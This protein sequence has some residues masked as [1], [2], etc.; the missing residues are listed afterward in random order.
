MTWSYLADDESD[1]KVGPGSPPLHTCFRK[2]QSGNPSGRSRKRLA[3]F[4]IKLHRAHPLPNP[5]P[6]KGPIK[7][8]G[9]YQH[10]YWVLPLPRWGRVGVGVMRAE[11]VDPVE[12]RSGGTP[13]RCVGTSLPWS[14]ST[15]STSRAASSPCWGRYAVSKAS[16]DMLIK[17]Y[18]GEISKTRVRAKLL[19][20]GMC[21][22]G[23]APAPF[24]AKT[25]AACRHRKASPPPSSPLHS[26][27]APA[28]A[29]WS[30]T[31]PFR[32]ERLSERGRINLATAVPCASELPSPQ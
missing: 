2:G 9:L 12:N 20:P 7:G 28:T 16:L 31:P 17:I 11:C 30:W 29:R 18:A 4:P 5:S 1:H 23:C 22:P 24:P 19:D 13:P 14:R 21:A 15:T 10:S 32:C 3:R 6:I 25:R 8:E 27:H 26:P